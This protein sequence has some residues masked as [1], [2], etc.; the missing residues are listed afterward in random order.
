[1]CPLGIVQLLQGV[2]CTIAYKCLIKLPG[3]Y[4]DDHR[5]SNDVC[6][7]HNDVRRSHNDVPAS[8]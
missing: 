3:V 1:M 5:S 6:R 4:Y 2:H 8:T 7:S